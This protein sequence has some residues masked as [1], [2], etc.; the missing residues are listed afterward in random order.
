MVALYGRFLHK[1]FS[2]LGSPKCTVS[3]ADESPYFVAIQYKFRIFDNG[4]K[5]VRVVESFV[6]IICAT[7]RF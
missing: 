3:A 6:G 7:P 5:Y 2:E 1:C 4:Q